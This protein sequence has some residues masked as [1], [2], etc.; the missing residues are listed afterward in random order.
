M[1]EYVTRH[2]HW[3]SHWKMILKTA[4][5]SGRF[6]LRHLQ[7]SSL[8]KRSSILDTLVLKYTHVQV[9]RHS[10]QKESQMFEGK[11]GTRNLD[12]TVLSTEINI[13]TSVS[14]FQAEHTDKNQGGLKMVAD[15]TDKSEK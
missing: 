13:C 7:I 12:L 15:K 10:Q 14:I 11:V 3:K 5:I 2:A 6:V 9:K 4:N 1:V 8:N